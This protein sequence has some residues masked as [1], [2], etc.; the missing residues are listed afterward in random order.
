MMKLEAIAEWLENKNLSYIAKDSGVAY[1]F[2]WRAKRGELINPNYET[3]K[4]LSDYIK[5]LKHEPAI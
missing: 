3:V 2:V 5:A 4:K 1:I